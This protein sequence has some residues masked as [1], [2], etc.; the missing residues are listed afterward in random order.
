MRRDGKGF[1]NWH[2]HHYDHHH[3]HHHHHHR[4]HTSRSSGASIVD[5]I[6]FVVIIIVIIITS[7]HPQLGKY[8]GHFVSE[9]ISLCLI[10]LGLH[11]LLFSRPG[12][13]GTLSTI[14]PF[15]FLSQFLLTK[16]DR[17]TARAG[18]F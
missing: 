15:R 16:K 12:G 11:F 8:L 13:Q 18:H 6:I 7:E 5:M 14:I 2:Q 17:S 10:I 3:H 1:R 4:N 9:P